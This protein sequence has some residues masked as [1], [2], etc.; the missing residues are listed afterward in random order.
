MAM[1]PLNNP[2]LL[3]LVLAAL[4]DTKS[5]HSCC[6]VNHQWLKAASKV[7]RVGKESVELLLLCFDERLI[8]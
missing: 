8:N 2:E 3:E 1:N 6:C 4:E 5:L 7:L